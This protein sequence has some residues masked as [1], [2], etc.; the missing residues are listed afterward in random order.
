V[1]GDP[2]VGSNDKEAEI[3]ESVPRILSWICAL[4]IVEADLEWR[5]KRGQARR[6]ERV[7]E[8]ERGRARE[9]RKEGG[10]EGRR[11]GGEGLPRA[12]DRKVITRAMIH[13][14]LL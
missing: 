9:R 7:A 6:S 4:L 1:S 13:L 12:G 10:K 8:A 3:E 5:Q 11:E 2:G 14:A